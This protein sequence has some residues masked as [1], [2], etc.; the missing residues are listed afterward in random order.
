MKE[1]F[2]KIALIPAYKPGHEMLDVILELK[3]KDFDIVVVNDGSGIDYSLFAVFSSL[4]GTVAL[5]NIM[6]RVFSS[7]ANYTLNKKLVFKSDGNTAR[8]AAKYFALAAFILACNTMI[9]QGLA[10]FGMN[11]YLAKIL[12]EAFLFTISWLV[13]RNFIF[14]KKESVKI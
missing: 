5:P 10:A 13:Q 8:S 3:E 7:C 6:A 12:T 2:R 4:L 11:K 9:L 1:N 14:G